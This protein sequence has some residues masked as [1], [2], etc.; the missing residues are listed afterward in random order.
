[1]LSNKLTFSLTFI[2]MLAL[3]FAF[4]ATPAMG[5]ALSPVPGANNW[6]VVTKI[7]AG[8]GNGL[9]GQTVQANS[10]LANLVLRQVYIDECM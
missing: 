4:V 8:A 2:V 1:M 7:A 10:D 9:T 3:A 5:Q 6:V